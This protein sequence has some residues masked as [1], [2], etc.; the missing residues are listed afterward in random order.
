MTDDEI[1]LVTSLA[2]DKSW[3]PLWPD[4]P[5]LVKETLGPIETND[6]EER[7]PL[8][9]QVEEITMFLRQF[10]YWNDL[11]P[12]YSELRHWLPILS[13]KHI[14]LCDLTPQAWGH[15]IQTETVKRLTQ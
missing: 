6:D 14:K 1:K 7:L 15:I 2:G 8:Y 5:Y 3:S 11:C 10:C 9:F 4:D 13:Q 12:K